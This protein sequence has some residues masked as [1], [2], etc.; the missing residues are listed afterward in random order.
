MK[1]IMFVV[2][3]LAGMQVHGQI[4]T[5]AF[6]ERLPYLYYWDTNW[7]DSK[8]LLHPTCY[9]YSLYTL[10]H[11]TAEGWLSRGDAF[12]GRVCFTDTPLKII[13]IAGLADVY[14]STVC[15]VDTVL[16]DRLPEYFQL[17]QM[18]GENYTDC[19][20]LAETRWDTVTPQ[21]CM[22]FI[23]P[24][25]LTFTDE[26]DSSY[27]K[28]RETYFEKPVIVHDT[29]CVGG[30]THNN[31][32]H[33]YDADLFPNG[34]SQ[35]YSWARYIPSTYAFL[36]KWGYFGD[37]P[38]YPPDPP[39]FIVKYFHPY[40]SYDNPNGAYGP[41][42]VYD[43]TSF[44]RI[45]P[46]IRNH[47]MPN[48]FWLGFFAIFDTDF[49][50]DACMG[51]ATTGLY[52]EAVDTSGT[53]TLAWDDSGV[54]E[55]QVAVAPWGV[56]ADSGM[57]FETPINYLQVMGLDTGSWY[58]AR[59]RTLCDSVLYG[60][61]SDSVLFYMPGRSCVMPTGLHVVAVDSAMVSLAWDAGTASAWQV[62]RGMCDLGM[63]NAQTVT[64]QAPT[65]TVADLPFGNAWYW[66]RVRVVC[67][68]DFWSDWTDT[69][70]FY[71]P[72]QHTGGGPDD[73]TQA[74]NLV[75]QYTYLMPNPA[76]DEVTVAS[77]FRVKAVELYGSD[78]KLL[79]RQEV[80]AV[81]TTLSLEGLPAGIYF[82]RVR[83]SAGVTTKRLVVE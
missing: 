47:G 75:E 78:G 83:T 80:N 9:A 49:V 64:T 42:N 38:H 60:A 43:T 1:K 22:S 71:V 21:H 73:T 17:Y 13:G 37:C 54:D 23:I 26:Q 53:A 63:S 52:V 70:R 81:G 33:G 4:D 2:M 57:L 10:G 67:D 44:Q 74:I 19:T 51:V 59:V 48:E 7:I 11:S 5:V 24:G 29:F 12:W 3:L 41:N 62:E 34:P 40:I 68:T 25:N 69:V 30:T 15:V 56:E 39:Y 28:L 82:V 35:G 79:Q 76:R 50:Y 58:V 55:W 14:Q 16:S 6:G 65:L 66:A 20:L 18:G 45:Y 36:E 77:S 32:A 46:P 8:C 61:W 31:L 72:N 27:F